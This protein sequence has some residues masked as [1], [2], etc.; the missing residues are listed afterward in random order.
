MGTPT[1]REEG[2]DSLAQIQCDAGKG[3]GA[4]CNCGFFLRTAAES[5]VM[6][7]PTGKGSMK[8]ISELK[9]GFLYCSLNF[10]SCSTCTW[11]AAGL[12]PEA[13]SFSILWA[14]YL[15]MKSGGRKL[16]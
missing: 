8:V 2:A 1:L 10:F 4:G 12:A 9:S 5:T 11:T 14:P 13:L 3:D 7:S 16:K 6:T 15:S